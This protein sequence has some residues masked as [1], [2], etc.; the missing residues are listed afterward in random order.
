MHD[1]AFPLSNIFSR[2]LNVPGFFSEAVH[3]QNFFFFGRGGGGGNMLEGYFLKN[4][5]A[6][7]VVVILLT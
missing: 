4:Y 7:T 3:V 2:S 5:Q 1:I 6:L